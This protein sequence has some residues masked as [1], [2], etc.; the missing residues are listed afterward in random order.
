VQTFLK[1]LGSNVD[2]SD[3]VSN[4]RNRT[5]TFRK[6]DDTTPILIPDGGAGIWTFG[7]HLKHLAAH[8]G[9]IPLTLDEFGRCVICV[10]RG[11][12]RPNA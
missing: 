2:R 11:F 3:A 4:G 5:S 7:D 1:T 12:F 10:R 6:A 9:T 8:A